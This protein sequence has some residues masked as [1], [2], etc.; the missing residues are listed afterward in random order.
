MRPS[1]CET[2]YY[3]ARKEI[4]GSEGKFYICDTRT[5]IHSQEAALVQTVEENIKRPNCVERKLWSCSRDVAQFKL[6]S[7]HFINTLFHEKSPSR[8]RTV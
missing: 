8:V 5:M 6:T 3:F 7:A 4:S 2:A 1:G